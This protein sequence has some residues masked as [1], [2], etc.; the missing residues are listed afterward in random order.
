MSIK[1]IEKVKEIERQAEALERDY[2]SQLQDLKEAT[3]TKITQLKETYESEIE[4]FKELEQEHLEN[5]VKNLHT[6]IQKELVEQT[7]HL[8]SQFK[9]KQQELVNEVVKEVMRRYGNS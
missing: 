7:V 4:K 8:E 2:E 5:K 3:E 9:F 1:T 6:I